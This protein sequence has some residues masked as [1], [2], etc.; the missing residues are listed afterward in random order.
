MDQNEINKRGAA[1]YN[2]MSYSAAIEAAKSQLISLRE[3]EL[4][5]NVQE[6]SDLLK[7]VDLENQLQSHIDQI[8]QLLRLH[9]THRKGFFEQPDSISSEK[10]Q[11]Y[12]VD[13]EGHVVALVRTD[14]AVVGG[15]AVSFG[16]FT[17]LVPRNFSFLKRRWPKQRLREDVEYNDNLDMDQQS[18]E[19]WDSLD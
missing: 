13:N 14:K 9:I 5:P 12:Y 7:I 10:I 15:F 6:N 1:L 8:V 17:E 2:P 11:C 3:G 4:D 18:P 19:W 16:I